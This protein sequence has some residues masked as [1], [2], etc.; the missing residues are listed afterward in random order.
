MRLNASD[1]SFHLTG[2]RPGTYALDVS[3]MNFSNFFLSRI[4]K[5]GV[6]IKN[7]EVREGEQVNDVRVFVGYGKG[8]IRGQ[9]KVE[10]GEFPDLSGLAISAKRKGDTMGSGYKRCAV[11]IR[12]NFVLEGL[13]P[14]EYELS[15]GASSRKTF[16][17]LSHMQNPKLQTVTVTND[18]E[19]HITIVLQARD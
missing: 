6:E 16:D 19:S 10:S 11:D 7:L 5:D 12:G 18:A 13:A 15:L 14:G 9:V 4:E 8:V 3:M 2:L 17:A 1:R